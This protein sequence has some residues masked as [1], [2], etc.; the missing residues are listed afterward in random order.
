MI[1][2]YEQLTHEK[3]RIQIPVASFTIFNPLEI[4]EIEGIPSRN[5]PSICTEQQGIDYFETLLSTDKGKY[6][7]TYGERIVPQIEIIVDKLSN[8]TNNAQIIVVKQDDYSLKNRPCLQW[9]DF[10]RL[11]GN[12]L[13]MSVVFRSWDIFAMPYNL[14]GLAYLFE[15]IASNTYLTINNMHCFSPG[16]NCRGDMLGM[17]KKVVKYMQLGV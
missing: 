16:L 6:D 3:K 9:I 8:Y 7:Y 10:K 2:S 4:R 13:D 1:G 12:R 15:Y 11:P 17:L 5:I 14:I